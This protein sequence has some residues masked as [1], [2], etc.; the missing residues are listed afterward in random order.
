MLFLVFG[1]SCSGKTSVLQAL[2]GRVDRLAEH[3]F[4]EIGVPPH[5]TIDWRHR[6]NEHWL[7]RAIEYQ[8]DGIDLLLAGQTPLGEMLA[9]PSA[10]LIESISACLL[11]CDDAARLDRMHARGARWLEHSAG[12]IEDYLEWA[13]WMRRH[14]V[15]PQWMREVIVRG[16]AD[17]RW[18]RWSDWQAGDPRWRVHVVDTTGRSVE[19]TAEDLRAWIEA[20]RASA[21]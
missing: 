14:A 11:D 18:E 6:G 21:A 8:H 10:P 1:S 3:D 20:E 7:R 19:Q 13:E 9:S 15:D 2:R 16:D 12:T 5:A 4:D 17:M